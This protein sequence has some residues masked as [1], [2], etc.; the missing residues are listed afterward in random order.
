[1]PLSPILASGHWRHLFICPD[2]SLFQ[3]VTVF[4]SEL[5]P[6]APLVDLKTY[7]NKRAL[8]ETFQG[9]APTL[10]FL[11]VGS[12]RDKALGVLQDFVGAHPNVPVIALNALSDPHLILL[13]LRQGAKE[14]LSAPFSA[15]QLTAALERLAKFVVDSGAG[16]RRTGKVF[17]VVPG[18]GAAG[19][20]TLACGLAYNL[21]RLKQ[22]QK[23][24]LAD[25][26]PVTGTVSFQLKLRSQY[27]FIDILTN[28][29]QLDESIWK[30]AVASF[31][32]IDVLLSPENPVDG[33]S[34]SHEVATLINFARER[35]NWIVLDTRGPYGDWG[36][37]IARCS[38]EILL[39]TTNE[40]PMLHA[41]QRAI[42]HLD[43]SGID[44]SKIR[45]LVNR[46]NAEAGLGREAIEMALHLD[47]YEVLPNDFDSVQK[48]LLEGKP[49]AA[50]SSLGKGVAALASR[51]TGSKQQATGRKSL[52][53]GFFS[54]FESKA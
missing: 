44:R 33:F 52:F 42:A 11:D 20:S 35:Y 48:A 37:T 27:S 29:S 1:M 41:A 2:R 46:H 23:V 28:S 7:P 38:D 24:L 45:L 10:C 53:S 12:D 49:V 25:L 4:L 21:S 34:G 43:R 3:Q 19:A 17:C 47:V 8:A 32:G 26:D 18:K 54:M 16:T 15:E 36:L 51:L 9:Q 5:T 6:S 40:L 14:F 30:A 39:V 31:Q 50:S 13:C 22:G